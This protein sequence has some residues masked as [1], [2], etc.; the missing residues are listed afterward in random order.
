[1][2]EGWDQ[3]LLSLSKTLQKHTIPI[4]KKDQLLDDFELCDKLIK[5]MAG[6]NE[7]CKLAKQA[8]E[9]IESERTRFDK[10]I[11]KSSG[12]KKTQ[13]SPR[14]PAPRPSR[15]AKPQPPVT[16]GEAVSSTAGGAPGKVNLDGHE[17]LKKYLWG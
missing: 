13:T 4:E 16:S 10:Y 3:Q 17:K 11:G 7:I 6:Y 14:Q 2:A 8:K 15:A 5:N 9:R 12:N 1:M